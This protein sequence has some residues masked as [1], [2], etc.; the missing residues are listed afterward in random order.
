MEGTIIFHHIFYK[1]LN[2]ESFPIIKMSK[3]QTKGTATQE[4]SGW[5]WKQIK[6]CIVG[7]SKKEVRDK[8]AGFD[9]DSTLI[10]TKS[11]AK[12]A[13]NAEDW[14]YWN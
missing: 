11:G 9:M 3:R 10:E 8:I 1:I 4:V 2:I 6:T 13:K 14:V 5:E 7:E 12:F